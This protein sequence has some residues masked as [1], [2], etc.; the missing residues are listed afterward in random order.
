M[1]LKYVQHEC[2]VA[3]VPNTLCLYRVHERSMINTTTLFEAEMV[4]HFLSHYGELLERYE[5][6]EKVFGIQ[7]DKIVWRADQRG[8]KAS[9]KPGDASDKHGL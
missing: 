8:G 9:S 2:R 3:F 5:P 7:R 4:E 1:W 6:R